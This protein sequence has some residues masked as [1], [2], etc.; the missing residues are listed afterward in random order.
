MLLAKPRNL[1]TYD[2]ILVQKHREL[3]LVSA[4]LSNLLIYCA[5]LSR[6]PTSILPHLPCESPVEMNGDASSVS[7]FQF[8]LISTT[9]PHVRTV[10][11][12]RPT[13]IQYFM[14]H[15]IQ[16]SICYVCR[17]KQNTSNL[18]CVIY[19]IAAP[20][21]EVKLVQTCQCH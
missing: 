3:A 13:S 7:S 2:H 5:V 21:P 16:T 20:S 17:S 4:L 1:F 12:L 11:L 18:V 6:K 9:S 14:K 8:V 19:R 10:L 15:E